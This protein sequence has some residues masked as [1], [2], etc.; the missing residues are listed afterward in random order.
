M[1]DLLK[2]LHDTQ[3]G[4]T[5]CLN[6]DEVQ[7]I[8]CLIPEMHCGETNDEKQ[9]DVYT[10]NDQDCWKNCNGFCTSNENAE[11]KRKS[12]LNNMQKL[13]P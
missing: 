5:I 12:K 13:T 9:K 10:C 8:L 2:R 7:C 1:S 3:E 6:H 11:C 4:E